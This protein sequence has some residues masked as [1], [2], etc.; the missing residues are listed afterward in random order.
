MNLIL[1]FIYFFYNIFLAWSNLFK[2]SK[3]NYNEK[4]IIIY[5]ESYSEW[6]F[7]ENNL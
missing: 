6:N 4:K 7:F 5:L 2:I 1:K 3:L